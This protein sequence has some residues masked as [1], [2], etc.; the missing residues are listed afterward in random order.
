M[1]DMTRARKGTQQAAPRQANAIDVRTKIR[2]AESERPAVRVHIFE[3]ILF[4][5]AP[6]YNMTPPIGYNKYMSHKNS[7]LAILKRRYL[8]CSDD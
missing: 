1:R 7:R 4:A 5:V 2:R 6:I 8:C 3:N